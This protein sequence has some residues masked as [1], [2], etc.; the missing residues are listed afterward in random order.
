MTQTNENVDK[1]L[2]QVSDQVVKKRKFKRILISSILLSI[3]VVISAVIISLASIKFNLQ[4]NFLKGADAYNVYIGNNHK[5]YI[6]EDSSIYDEF[7]DLYNGEFETTILPAMFT[8][9][10]GAY[11]IEE[12]TTI[13]YS[14]STEKT[15]MSSALK[16]ELGGNYIEF[17]FNE[18]QKVTDKDGSQYYSTRY[19]DGEYALKFKNCYLKLDSEKSDT[20][21][22]YLGT[23]DSSKPTITKVIVQTSSNALYDYFA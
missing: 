8:G 17:V 16:S 21:T 11:S 12:S 20:M 15:G 13:F 1:V 3:V 14:N 5:K 7:M 18:E 2:E 10:L 9:K 4:P 22:F 23:Y 6:D 19:K